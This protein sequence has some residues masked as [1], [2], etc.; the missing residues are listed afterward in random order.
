MIF[1]YSIERNFLICEYLEKT[2]RLH[3]AAP[4]YR[5]GETTLTYGELWDGACHMAELL[6]RQGTEPVVLCGEKE[7]YMLTG[8]LACLL[9]RRAYVPLD[10]TQPKQ[11]AEKIIR[12]SGASLVLGE[13]GLSPEEL[14]RYAACAAKEQTGDTA[15]ILFTSGTTGEPKGVPISRGN[16][17]HFTDWIRRLEPLASFRRCHVL[18]QAGFG[19]DLSTADLY[20]ALTGGHTLTALTDR[21]P[22]AVTALMRAHEIHTAMITPTFGRMCLLDPLFCAEQIPSLRCLYFCGEMLTPGLVKKLWERFPAL[23]ILNAYGPTEATSAVSAARI[24]REMTD[25]D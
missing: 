9:S 7:P 14:E 16:L 3:R 18:N 5:A 25:W 17:L 11:R 21:D 24:L 10:R 19:F 13:G 22:A 15:Y 23:E 12:A 2:A 20:Y 6:R 4:A 8:I 1:L